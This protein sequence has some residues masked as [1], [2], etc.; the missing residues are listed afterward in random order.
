MR[1]EKAENDLKRSFNEEVT[2]CARKKA[3]VVENTVK[4]KL[5]M[6]HKKTIFCGQISIDTY[7]L[8][9]YHCVALFGR[10]GKIPPEILEFNRGKV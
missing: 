9:C 7:I 2:K 1:G 8:L 4:P 5:K 10:D 3:E 6:F